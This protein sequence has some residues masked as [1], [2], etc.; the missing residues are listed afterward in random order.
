[1]LHD[2][3]GLHR[4]MILVQ[5]T[6]VLRRVPIGKVSACGRGDRCLE[7]TLL[8][9][10][11]V[12]AELVIAHQGAVAACRW[13]GLPRTCLIWA[14]VSGDAPVLACGTANRGPDT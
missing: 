8:R 11:L 12:V 2:D 14:R 13:Q 4:G 6:A 7:Q 5:G 3:N 10:A 9:R 1:M